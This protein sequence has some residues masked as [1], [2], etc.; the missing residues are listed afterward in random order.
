MGYTKDGQAIY[1]RNPAGKI[2]EEF[3]G[4]L[5]GPLD[6]LKRKLGT[7]ARPAWQVLSNDTGFGRKVYNPYAETPEQ[8][9]KNAGRIAMTFMS[10]QVPTGA[11]SAANDLAHGEGD[12]TLNKLQLFGPLAGVTFSRGAPGGP[13]MGEIYRSEEK[14]RYNLNTALPDIRKMIQRG[15]IDG[16]TSKM[17]QIGVPPKLQNYYIRTTVNPQSRMSKRKVDD[18][19]SRATD[20]EIERFQRARKQ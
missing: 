17:T 13:A 11:I 18:F 10:S 7:L 8:W 19:L 2:G 5:T 6:M 3:L 9:I 14:Y 1:A 12:P 15:D 20:E 4:Y 16:A